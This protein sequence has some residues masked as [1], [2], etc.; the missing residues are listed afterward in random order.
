M[1]LGYGLLWDS[2][3]HGL[4]WV[5]R[6]QGSSTWSETAAF[7]DPRRGNFYVCSPDAMPEL[8]ALAGQLYGNVNA[9]ALEDVDYWMKEAQ[10]E[11]SRFPPGGPSRITFE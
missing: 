8:L 9:V 4:R 7:N 10:L 3:E 6:N 1:T 11:P 5:M 2:D